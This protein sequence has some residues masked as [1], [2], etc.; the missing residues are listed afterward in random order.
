[1]EFLRF[2]SSIPGSY[3]GCCAV[4]IIQNFSG[5]HPDD[6]ASIELVCG[7]GGQPLGTFLGKTYRE[8]FESRLRIG[9]FSDEDMPNHAFLC[10]M[11]ESQIS[12]SNGSAWLKILKEN[13]FEFIRAVDNSVYSGNV[14][15]EDGYDEYEHESNINYIF[16]LFRNIGVGKIS[17]PFAPPPEWTSLE[18]GVREIFDKLSPDDMA[19]LSYNR[20]QLHLKRWN[21]IAFA[22]L[23]SKEQ[24]KA[25]GVP[26]TYAGRRSEFPQES[27]TAREQKLKDKEKEG[28]VQATSA[29]FAA[30]S[31]TL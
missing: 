9:T 25:D 10:I 8:I 30:A 22:K 18:G 21:E 28:K 4:D 6:K 16:G 31:A 11:T 2:G 29:P 17:N 5:G 13:G 12:F 7:D 23:Y 20:E 1:M 26:I 3:W 24:L 14:T 15:A 19:N 27:E